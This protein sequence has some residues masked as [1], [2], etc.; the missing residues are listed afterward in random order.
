MCLDPT[1]RA[2]LSFRPCTYPSKIVLQL[3]IIWVF[4]LITSDCLCGK[5]LLV[6]HIVTKRGAYWLKFSQEITVLPLLNQDMWEN[7]FLPWLFSQ[8][9]PKFVLPIPNRI[10]IPYPP[11]PAFGDNISLLWCFYWT[12]Y[13]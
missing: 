7:Q 6:R 2:H 3:L 5:W 13:T 12:I 10:Q 8:S 9:N 4:V 11:I 1:N